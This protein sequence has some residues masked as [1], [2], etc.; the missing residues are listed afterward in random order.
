LSVPNIPRKASIWAD[1]R[2]H[3]EDDAGAAVPGGVQGAWTPEDVQKAI[4]L[5][6]YIHDTVNGRSYQFK[7]GSLVIEKDGAFR[8]A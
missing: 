6:D 7:D 5:I 4:S 8:T 2:Q 1:G 3:E